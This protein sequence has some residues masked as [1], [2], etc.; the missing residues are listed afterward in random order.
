MMAHLT[1]D[2]RRPRHFIPIPGQLNEY[3]MNVSQF[4]HHTQILGQMKGGGA[5]S[6]ALTSSAGRPLAWLG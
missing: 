1:S 4:V 2:V 6:W 3:G 5:F